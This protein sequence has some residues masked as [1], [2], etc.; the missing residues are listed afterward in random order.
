[1]S[2]TLIES[3]RAWTVTWAAFAAN[4][5]TF[6][7]LFSFGVYLTPIAETFE[8]TTGPVSSLFSAAVLVYY[9]SGAIGGRFGD[10]YGT[11]PVVAVGAVTIGVAL[12]VS[13]QTTSLWQLY[14]VFPVV[15]IAVG[16]CYP[17]LIG[18]VGQMFERRRVM[19]MA[20]VLAGVGAGTWLMPSIARTLIDGRGWRGTFEIWAAVTMVVIVATALAI[21]RRSAAVR[22]DPPRPLPAGV[23]VGDRRFRRLYVALVL[24]SPGFYAPL[25]FLNDYAVDQGISEG[26]AAWLVGIIGGATVVA[27][28]VIGAL[29]PRFDPLTQYRISYLVMT[30]GL[31]TWLFAGGFYWALAL[32][33]ALHGIGWAVWVTAAPLVL[34]EWY[35]VQHLGGVLGSFYTGLGLGAL[36]GPS[37]SGFVI[38]QASYRWAIALVVT[39]NLAAIA[40]AATVVG[41][42]R[43]SASS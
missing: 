38:D 15:G 7:V 4:F 24:V 40:A 18:S 34:A 26:A 21:P 22:A 42:S 2:T 12:Y 35:G 3:R 14:L 30:A 36:L 5:V 28:L 20:I 29:G 8:T 9:L 1:M 25:A 16:C 39:F 19:A 17:P 41:G 33:A 11:R 23:L 13:A 32:A 37:V 27:R 6:G 31:T 43:T 10:R